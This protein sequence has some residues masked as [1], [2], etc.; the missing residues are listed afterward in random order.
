MADQQPPYIEEIEKRAME[1]LKRKQTEGKE[2]FY[3]Y[4]QSLLAN[5]LSLKK[6]EAEHNLLQQT[7]RF[8]RILFYYLL[9]LMTVETFMLFIII[10][11]VSLPSH[12]LVMPQITLQVLVGATIAQISAMVIVIIKSVYPD[13]INKIILPDNSPEK[14]KSDGG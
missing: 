8:R 3:P 14:T 1:A 10:V 9:L 6:R 2:E 13:S 12:W 11:A 7:I 4:N 5:M